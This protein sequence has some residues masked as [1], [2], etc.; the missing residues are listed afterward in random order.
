[1]ARMLWMLDTE[2]L[3]LPMNRTIEE[4]ALGGLGSYCSN[5]PSAKFQ[6]MFFFR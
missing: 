6:T 2:A 1:M 4:E 5:G 3:C